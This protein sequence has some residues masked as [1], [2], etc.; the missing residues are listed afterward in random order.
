[1]LLMPSASPARRLFHLLH[2]RP[3][4]RPAQ[5]VANGRV[6]ILQRRFD[7]PDR[8]QAIFRHGT[9]NERRGS[10]NGADR[11]TRLPAIFPTKKT[12]CFSDTTSPP[13]SAGWLKQRL[14]LSFL[15]PQ[16]APSVGADL[17]IDQ[18]AGVR[19]GDEIH[20]V[21]ALL[22]ALGLSLVLHARLGHFLGRPP[23]Q[24]NRRREP[25]GLPVRQ[26]MGSCPFLNHSLKERSA[27]TYQRQRPVLH[28]AQSCATGFLLSSFDS[29]GLSMLNRRGYCSPG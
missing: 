9:S 3:P 2:A 1:M 10:I 14:K 22:L 18:L 5:G 28:G 24:L 4:V 21:A 27:P 29:F 23:A 16:A 8:Q 20:A 11:T 13:N 26:R 15:R 19:L 25:K 7:T 6:N 17:A 12:S